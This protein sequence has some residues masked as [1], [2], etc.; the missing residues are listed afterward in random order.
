MRHP[1]TLP[2]A[3]ACWGFGGRLRLV[4]ACSFHGPEFLRTVDL[5]ACCID[6][7]CVQ[8]LCN[9]LMPEGVA[10]WEAQEK[11]ERKNGGDGGGKR[12]G[13]GAGASIAGGYP[14]TITAINLS[15]N[16]DITD[17]GAAALGQLLKH[18]QTLT[19]LRMGYTVVTNGGLHKLL[20]AAKHNKTLV[21]LALPGHQVCGR[22]LSLSRSLSLTRSYP[23]HARNTL[24]RSPMHPPPGHHTGVRA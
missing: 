23:S 16:E 9:A 11:K 15:S 19:H 10:E 17:T 20:K 21:S 8:T 18:D 24:T 2:E 4:C 1:A 13:G 14:S 3:N 7:A 22:S 6:D 5:R 12:R